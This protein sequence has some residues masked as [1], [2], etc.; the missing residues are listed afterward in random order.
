M[1]IFISQAWEGSHD[2]ELHVNLQSCNEMRCLTTTTVR[3][4]SCKPTMV[5]AFVC[6][7]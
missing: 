7:T 4:V 2:P 6:M 5:E 1:Q 3:V